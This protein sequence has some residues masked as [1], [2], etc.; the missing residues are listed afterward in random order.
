MLYK[1]NKGAGYDGKGGL[2]SYDGKEGR[3]PDHCV[4]YPGHD[5]KGRT[6]TTVWEERKYNARLKD[7]VSK[8]EFCKIMANLQLAYPKQIDK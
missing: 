5:Y 3:L 2:L 7:G 6:C 8:E 4:L 1:T